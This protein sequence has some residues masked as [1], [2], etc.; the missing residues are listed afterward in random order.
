[1]QARISDFL[2]ATTLA[3][4]IGM[5]VGGINSME[6]QVLIWLDDAEKTAEGNHKEI[7]NAFREQ[8]GQI[9]KIELFLGNK[10]PEYA[11]YMEPI[12]IYR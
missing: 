9:D 3:L 11:P 5:W 4:V 7:M 12:K 10:Y 1:M 6:K 2:Q 8:Q